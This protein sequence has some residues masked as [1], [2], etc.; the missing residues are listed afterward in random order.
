MANSVS[1]GPA[2]ART[3]P[4]S[5]PWELQTVLCTMVLLFLVTVVLY[6][7]FLLLLHSFQRD[8][9]GEEIR[10]SLEGWRLALSEPAMGR[11]IWNT[12]TLTLTRQLISLPF[13]VFIAWLLARTDLPGR[14]NLEFLFWIGFF[15]PSLAVTLGWIPLLDPHYGLLNK[16]VGWFGVEKGPF[17]IYSWWGIV[18]THL[19]ANTLVIKVMLLTTAFRNM[20]S[21]LEESSWMAGANPLR[22]LL[23][24]VVPVMA[25]SILIVVLISTIRSLEAF[26]IELILGSPPRI[27]V[28]STLI[29]R[30]INQEEPEYG[31]ATS[32]SVLIL[33]LMFPFVILQRWLIGRHHY[34]TVTGQFK[35]QLLPLG[36]WKWPAFGFVCFMVC[37]LTVVPITSLTVATFMRFFGFFQI[38]NPWTLN[39]W[40]LIFTDPLFLSS[41]RNTTI[42]AFG[43]AFVSVALFSLVAYISVRTRF[44]G[45]AAIDILSW[46]P[47]TLPGIILGLG[48][49]WFFLGVSFLK[50][51]YGSMV[52]LILVSIFSYM[53]LSV[54]VIKTNMIHLGFDLEEASWMVGG[55]WWYTLRR[56]VL[57]ILAPALMLVGVMNFIAAARNISTLALLSTSN[58]Q[59][60][61]LLQLDYMA[62]GNYEAASVVGVV[63]MLMT[64]GVA[65]LARAF[66]LR[67]GIHG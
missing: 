11:A 65:F 59:P 63:V 42:L 20:N 18:W 43:S 51:L 58:T 24:I 39:Q 17:N 3:R 33:A 19:M 10:F 7:L 52:G 21:S 60:L 9:P 45:R 40:H 35:A 5:W 37:L 41:L 56:I 23:R 57:P 55:S 29:Y 62:A 2:F 6:P 66:G 67:L 12:I 36:H 47:W 32:L 48:Y 31:A 25:P 14:S 1:S 8:V 4:W 38:P 53:T 61:A 13:G 49:L 54:Q 34:T 15:L 64:V 30:L 26:E 27:N 46:I 50:P 28:Y 22:T 44:W 16:L